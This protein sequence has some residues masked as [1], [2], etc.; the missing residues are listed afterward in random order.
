MFGIK[1]LII[2]NNNQNSMH[3]INDEDFI[4]DK[5]ISY[6]LCL[7]NTFF[8]KEREGP[9]PNRLAVVLQTVP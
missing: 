3:K 4:H 1:W 5:F 7:G 2:Q 8:R 6:I 9:P